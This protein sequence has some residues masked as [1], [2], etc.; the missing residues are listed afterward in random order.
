MP[1]TCILL[2]CKRVL[3]MSVIIVM[4]YTCV[5]DACCYCYVV[6]VCTERAVKAAGIT[7]AGVTFCY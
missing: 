5:T 3:L 4:L 7:G 2:C 6:G 1:V